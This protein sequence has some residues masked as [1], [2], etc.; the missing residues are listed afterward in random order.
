[1]TL[2]EDTSL[3][4]KGT[5]PGELLE[6]IRLEA[7]G[8]VSLMK[9][10]KKHV[11]AND[12]AGVKYY[13][14]EGWFDVVDQAVK[15]KY[16]I[17]YQVRRREDLLAE[18]AWRERDGVELDKVAELEESV[19]DAN[20]RILVL[21]FWIKTKLMKFMMVEGPM[22]APMKKSPGRPPKA[23]AFEN[24]SDWFGRNDGEDEVY[25]VE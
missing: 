5:N 8:T 17:D 24:E 2:I 7:L 21:S 22:E 1:M 6:A 14:R 25:R 3:A 16:K 10:W 13:G 18:I 19:R 11:Y 15:D 4:W 12:P 9:R 23:V 20:E